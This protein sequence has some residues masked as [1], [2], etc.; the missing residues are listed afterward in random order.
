MNNN[1]PIT[2]D[3]F[4]F[5]CKQQWYELERTSDPKLKFCHQCQKHVHF[6]S[7]RLEFAQYGSQSSC[8]A[9]EI[10]PRSPTPGYIIAGG[11]DSAY[12]PSTSRGIT[13]T[14]DFGSISDLSKSQLKAIYSYKDLGAWISTKKKNRI[15]FT[16]E[17]FIPEA[18]DRLVRILEKEQIEYSITALD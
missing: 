9:V 5:I 7:S 10:E 6:I 2:E 13:F 14:F 11:L 4:T 12:Y 3:D 1:N 16:I 17:L 8:V 15:E 18:F